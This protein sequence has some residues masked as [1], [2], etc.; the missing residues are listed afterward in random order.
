MK[1]SRG[2]SLIDFV[3]LGLLAVGIILFG[4]YQFGDDIANFF[5]RNDAENKFNNAR[6]VRFEKPRDLLSNVSVT[7][8][9]QPIEPPVEKII[10]QGLQSGEYI[11]TSGSSGRIAQMAEIMEE[12]VEQIT[13]FITPGPEGD[14]LKNKLD[15]YKKILR[16]PPAAPA[17]GPF[18]P[19]SG[20]DDGFLD[21]HDGYG[22]NDVL[23]R[24]L[25]MLKMA[26]TPDNS[27]LMGE[28][29]T[30]L[31]AYTAVIGGSKPKRKDLI[32]TLTTDLLNFNNALDYFIDPYLYIE[33]LNEERKNDVTQDMQLIQKLQ[34]EL[35]SLSNKEK[36]GI[37][38]RIRIIYGYGYSQA[39][40]MAYNGMQMCN[41]FSGT[42]TGNDCAISG[43]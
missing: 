40:P 23:E 21:I 25:N 27:A 31:N 11:Q 12:Y 15:E 43:P 6:T 37:A 34:D 16:K 13:P 26:A 10:S 33:Y 3:V 28:L 36:R 19:A 20:G 41:T 17:A 9:G 22:D 1:K 32:E 42:L 18:A 38:D 24:K 8:D 2:Q 7:F 4:V 14:T 39:S 35:S 5:A 30:A 29:E